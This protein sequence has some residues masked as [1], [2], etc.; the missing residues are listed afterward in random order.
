MRQTAL[1]LGA[2]GRLGR[3]AVLAFEGA[4]WAV[5]RFDR[6]T[7]RLPDAAQGVSVIVHGWNPPY[8]RWAAE[9]PGQV[10]AVIAAARAS[11]A[12]VILPGNVYVYGAGAPGV[13]GPDTPHRATNP[14]GRVRIAMEQALRDSGVQVIVV[15]AGD[16]LDTAPSGNWFDR[17]IARRAHKGRLAYPGGL[18]T[19]HAW[20]FLP[21]VARVMVALADR[22]ADL[23]SWTDVPVP[24]PAV[25]AHAL[26][27]GCAR[28]LGRPVV[29]RR[30]S[31]APLRLAQPF[32]PF[33]GGMVE[34]RYLWDMPHRLD[35]APL[36]LLCPGVAMT[37]L[38]QVLRAALDHQ[39][40]PDKAVRPGG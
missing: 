40:D 35:P 8:H 1:V 16:F 30:M 11:G 22:R 15:R 20:A 14:L 7:D 17:V 36:G 33:V 13:L 31:W 9:V 38:D 5:R 32:V 39:I 37:P 29:A 19:M 24:G 28:V 23:G 4:G 25:T 26:A 3:N 18:G 27:D 21:D 34:M 2:S 12:S 6:R 10:S